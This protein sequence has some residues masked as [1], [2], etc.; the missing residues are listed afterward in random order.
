[1]IKHIV[2]PEENFHSIAKRYDIE[3]PNALRLF[4]NLHCPEDDIMHESLIEGKEILIPN[5]PE[6]KIEQLKEKDEITNSIN[7]DSEVI[8]TLEN[9]SQ[10]NEQKKE[11]VTETSNHKGKHFVIQKGTCQCNQGFKLSNFKVTSHQKHYWNSPNA[12]ANYLAVT[13]DDVQLSSPNQPFG[14]CKL[15]PTS[16]GYLPCIY[17]PVGK[18]QKTYEK[19][20]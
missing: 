13:E 9:K 7:D 6:Y 14:Q 4:H 5:D 10:P 8:E 15:R 19:V 12:D 1:M 20:A 17:A 11:S 3:D 2:Q 18:W 16:G